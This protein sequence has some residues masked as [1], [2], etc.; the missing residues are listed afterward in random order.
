MADFFTFARAVSLE[1]WEQ[2]PDSV[3]GKK[4][5]KKEDAN[6]AKALG[7]G[8]GKIQRIDEPAAFTV[9]KGYPQTP[10]GPASFLLPLA[11]FPS[12]HFSGISRLSDT[13]WIKN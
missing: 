4:R 2:K 12:P 10:P 1:Q 11:M 7:Q 9:D 3:L 8:A 13:L 6:I 5:M